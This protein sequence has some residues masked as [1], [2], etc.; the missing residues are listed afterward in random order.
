MAAEVACVYGVSVACDGGWPWLV[1]NI[2]VSHYVVLPRIAKVA[3]VAWF[4]GGRGPV[5][6]VVA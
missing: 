3:E 6:I 5:I 1:S 2:Y 4:T